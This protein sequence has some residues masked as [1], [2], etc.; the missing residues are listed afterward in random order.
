MGVPN[1]SSNFHTL[2]SA[3]FAAN[4][5]N[6]YRYCI[7]AN[8]SGHSPGSSG[9]AE[10][11][12][13]NDLYVSLGTF[14][15]VGGTNNQQI[16]TFIHELGH[17]I[18][19]RHGG[20]ENLNRKPSYNSIMRYGN[21]GQFNGIDTN[22]DNF[23][24]AVFTYSQGMR[25]GLNENNLNENLGVCDNNPIDWNSSG[26]FQNPVS[27]SINGDAPLQNLLDGADWGSLILNFRAAGSG[28][29]NN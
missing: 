6:V 20:F 13:A 27:V 10:D 11:I 14:N 22:C 4:R 15:P 17:T 8:D 12:L 9:Q 24:D 25:A 16:G 5:L 1:A 18:N 2:K 7:F 3:N 29:D 28:W 21:P 23:G 19:L 26:T